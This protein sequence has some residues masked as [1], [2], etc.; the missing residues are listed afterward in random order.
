[1]EATRTALINHLKLAKD[2]PEVSTEAL[3]IAKYAGQ[4]KELAARKTGVRMNLPAILVMFARGNPLG[5]RPIHGF[6]LFFIAETKLL[7][8]KKSEADALLLAGEYAKWLLENHQ[9]DDANSYYNIVE[10]ERSEVSTLF[11]DHKYTI[12]EMP[13]NVAVNRGD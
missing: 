7:S 9:F 10:L 11:N 6:S 4:I 3:T 8:K 2:A 1:M 5:S 13:I 12:L